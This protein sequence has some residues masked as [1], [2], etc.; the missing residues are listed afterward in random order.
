[1]TDTPL[2]NPSPAPAAGQT[3]EAQ[4]AASE[5][6]ATRVFSQSV[7]ISGIRCV[8]AYVIFPWVLP[9]LGVA[10]GVGPWIG[11]VIGVVA[12]SFNIASI[13]RFWIADHRW[14]WPITVINLSVIG[15][16]LALLVIDFGNL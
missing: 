3:A 6:T 4:E 9:A 16:L 15:L 12:I 1:M 5:E 8:L 13:R 7:V 14:K 11:I 10:G 2:A